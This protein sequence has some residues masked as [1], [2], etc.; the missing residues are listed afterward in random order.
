MVGWTE[1]VGSE[2]KFHVGLNGD[3]GDATGD[4][5]RNQQTFQ[6]I[7][8]SYTS[9]SSFSRMYYHSC[10]AWNT[11]PFADGARSSAS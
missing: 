11:I 2:H 5:T 4:A 6:G 9:L 7:S 8:S 10:E 3:F 1:K